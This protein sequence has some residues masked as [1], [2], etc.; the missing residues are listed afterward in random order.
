[1]FVSFNVSPC[2]LLNRKLAKVKYN[3]ETPTRVIVE[4]HIEYSVMCLSEAYNGK[5]FNKYI[6]FMRRNK[7]DNYNTIS[8]S[9]DIGCV[10]HV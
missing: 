5:E 8:Y 6:F 1:M 10:Q 4:F 7:I 3:S 2:L 9:F